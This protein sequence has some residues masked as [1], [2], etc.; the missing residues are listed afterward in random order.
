MSLNYYINKFQKLGISRSRG[1]A[2]H[3]PILL[4]AIIELIEQGERRHNQ[5][6]LSPELIAA[7]LKLW[8]VL[9]SANHNADIGLPFFHLRSDGFWHFCPNPGFEALLSSGAKVR[10]VKTIQSAIAYAYFDEELFVL[11]QQPESRNVL[12]NALLNTWF[13]DKGEQVNQILRV[14]AFAEF[15][16]ELQATGGKVYQPDAEELKDET[17]EIVRDAAF[18]R[19]VVS[20]YGQRC[21]FCGLRV[22]HQGQIIVDGSHIK[23]FSQFYDDR[24]DNGVALCKNHHWAFDRGWFSITDDYTLLISSNLVEDSPNARPMRDFAGDRILL[25]SHS[26]YYPRLEALRW[27]RENV[28]GAV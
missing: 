17:K 18:R 10:T 28:F 5:I 27:H 6:S 4:L 7:F 1:P 23:P 2:P 19:V 24:I 15:Q 26:Q 3:K 21:A 11:L 25:P 9:G 14:N 22:I 12:V 20:V 16:Q 8:Q 13:A